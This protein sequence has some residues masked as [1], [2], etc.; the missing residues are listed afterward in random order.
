MSSPV[1]EEFER[2]VRAACESTPYV[3]TRTDDGFD[4]RLDLAD[5]Q[6]YGLF[7]KAGLKKTSIHHVK[8]TDDDY[9]ITDDSQEVR[10]TA[11]HPEIT[12]SASRQLG[13]NI[14]VGFEKTWAIREDG[15]VGKV[16]DYSFNS[17]EGRG[18]VTLV[19]KELG[20]KQRRGTA[21][22]IGLYAALSVPVGFALAGLV[23][24]V[25]WLTGNLP[26]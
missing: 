4:V 16:V 20:L 26:S 25:L 13:R 7:N 10:W 6:W 2:R 8:V 22:K 18:L 9:S 19:A 24:L 1:A 21:E 11:G 5:A 17:E 12:G 23:L 14:E 15:T 3:V